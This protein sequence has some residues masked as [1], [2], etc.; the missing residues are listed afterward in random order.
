[1][2]KYFR[3]IRVGREYPVVIDYARDCGGSAPSKAGHEW[4][5]TLKRE[6]S[7][8]D[9]QAVLKKKS[10]EGTQADADKAVGIGRIPIT[11][12]DTATIPPGKYY[13]ELSEVAPDGSVRTLLPPPEDYT[14]QIVVVPAVQASHE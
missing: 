4:W 9:A 7:H 12:S 5:F 1:M 14:D 8:T 11:S 3:P 6:L 2:S 10:A 13:W